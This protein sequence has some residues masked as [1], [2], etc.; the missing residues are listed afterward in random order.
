MRRLLAV[1]LILS[2]VV[3]SPALGA[4]ARRSRRSQRITDAQFL[5]LCEE[6]DEQKIIDAIKK[7]ANVNAKDS[8]GWAALLYVLL[9][10]KNIEIINAFINAGADVNIRDSIGLTVLMLVLRDYSD[11]PNKLALVNTLLKAGADVNANIPNTHWSVLMVAVMFNHNPEIITKLIEAGANINAKDNLGSTPLIDA[12]RFNSNPEIIN[13]LLK[14]GANVNDEDNRGYTALTWAVMKYAHIK[15]SLEKINALLDAGAH[16][17][18]LTL[19]YARD[20]DKLAGS[21][22]LKRLE[23][24]SK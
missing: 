16:V 21:D 23:E 20:N 5:K 7:G 3:A 6:G 18:R 15:S 24:L 4:K 2:V 14:A 8:D 1:L 19:N 17:D 11:S 22:A 13:V 10:N 9:S 12:T